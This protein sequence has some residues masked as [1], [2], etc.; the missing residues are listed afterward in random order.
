MS[1]TWGNERRKIV[2]ASY[3]VVKLLEISV[4]PWEIAKMKCQKIL[5]FRDACG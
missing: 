4:L 1:M 5:I 2:L 3:Y